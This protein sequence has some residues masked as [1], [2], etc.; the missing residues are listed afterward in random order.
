[1]R[2]R[3]FL[4]AAIFPV[5]LVLVSF[6]QYGISRRNLRPLVL[7]GG[8]LMVHSPEDPEIIRNRFDFLSSRNLLDGDPETGSLLKYPSSH[9]QGTFVFWDMGLTHFPPGNGKI[10]PAQRQARLFRIESGACHNCPGSLFEEYSRPKEIL[11]EVHYRQANDPDVDFFFPEPVRIYR[12]SLTLEDRPDPQDFPLN[13]P[14][15]P[16][17]SEYP[18]GVFLIVGK[19]TVNSVYPGK[20]RPDLVAIRELD[21]GDTPVLPSPAGN[22]RVPRIHFWNLSSNSV[23]NP[24]K[25]E[26]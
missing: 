25:T 8:R 23:R 9:P 1:M 14:L 20:I 12:K 13:L 3:A 26:R 21:Y 7:Q 10:S 17:T 11:L 2:F 18:R 24:G 19:I 16:N 15:P 5:L 4:L 22:S 6:F